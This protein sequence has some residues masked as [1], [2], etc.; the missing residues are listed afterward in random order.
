MNWSRNYERQ[1]LRY[2][3]QLDGITCALQDVALATMTFSQVAAIGFVGAW[4]GLILV[5]SFP[6]M[7]GQP[8]Q[9]G[10]RKELI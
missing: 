3:Q 8:A 7:A 4:A 1:L 2:H 9:V 6:D 10:A 5:V